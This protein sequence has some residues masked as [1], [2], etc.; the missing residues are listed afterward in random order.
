[1]GCDIHCYCE[2]RKNGKWEELKEKIFKSCYSEELSSDPYHGR[3]YD[4]FAILANVRNGRGFAGSDTGNGFMPISPLKGLPADVS[5]EIK[6]SSDSWDCDGH[7]HS[8][9]TLKELIDYN[10]S[11]KTFKRGVVNENE[12]KTFKLNGEPDGWCSSCSGPNIVMINNDE[13]ESF[14]KNPETKETGKEY[15]TRIIWGTTYYDAA[16]SFYKNTIPALKSLGNP[17]DVRL[18]FWFDN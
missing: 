6:K 10:W 15:Y 12:Y 17:E 11:Q 7:S 9:V 2:V 8:W 5:G 3:N 1:M 13:M 18:V 4:L 14:I 16:G